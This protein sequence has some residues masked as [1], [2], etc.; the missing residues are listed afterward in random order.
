MKMREGGTTGLRTSRLLFL[1]G[2]VFIAMIITAASLTIWQL[3]GDRIAD[4]MTDTR[5]LGIVL[6]AQTARTIQAVDLIV[7]ETQTMVLAAGL[8][9]PDQ[10]RQRM[11]TEDVHQFLQD[12]L[13][14]LPQA[15]AI[16]I[17]DDAGKIVNFSRTWP[18]PPIDTSDRDFFSYLRDHDDP[19]PFI[20]VPVINKVTGAW[21]IT[22]TR[23]I[24]GPHGEF[25]GIVLGVID[26]R[27]FENFWATSIRATD[28]VALF[29]SD[30]ILLARYP[31]VEKMIGQPIS[32]KSPW[33]EAA[34]SGGKTYRS[35]SYLDGIA[36]IVSVEQVHDFPLAVSATSSEAEALAPWRRRSLLI[37]IGALGAI[38]GFS[39]LLRA[40][41]VQFRRFSQS[42][43]RFRG[44]ALTS[45]DWF[46]ETDEHHRFSYLSPGI[47][48]FGDDR[49]AY[50]GHTRIEFAADAR[51]DTAKWEEHLAV[52]NRHEPF[53]GFS[54]SRNLADGSEAI[55][56]VSGDP[57]FDRSGRFLGYRG[58]ARDI[59][60]QVMDERILREAKEVAETASRTKSQF[61]A[62]VS[63]ELRTPL[64]AII[65]FSEMLE[66]GFAG[67]VQPKQQEYAGL[68]HQSGQ[69]LL[70]IINDILDLAHVESGKFEL[71]EEA[72]VDPRHIIDACVLL[73]RDRAS[74]SDLH[75]STEIEGR[76]PLLVAD[77]TRL[78][79]VLLNLISNAIKFTDPGG[80]IVVAGHQVRDGAIVFE[81][82]D[83]GLGMTPEEIEIALEPFGQ[84]DASNT[85]RHEGPG[86]GLPLARRLAEL[87]GGSLHVSSE[88]GLGTTVAVILPASRIV[89]ATILIGAEYEVDA[90]G[91]ESSRPSRQNQ[92]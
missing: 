24:S 56:S 61:L 81:V 18:V 87:H 45:S 5:H 35:P 34:A 19:R 2:T 55:A 31:R 84:V 48:D 86:L 89:D 23:R 72:G 92:R 42:E 63:H 13:R 32:R 73:M 50:I 67:S 78:K 49:A 26:T 30:G 69:H 20:G 76:L 91:T 47:G 59:T 1:S 8:A 64:N 9:D 54:Y 10:F 40:L 90:T 41:A 28:S 14:S 27:Y 62:N 66:Q 16:S 17:I 39:I 7:Q 77:P 4:E 52:L 33:Y 22:L 25:I 11:A 57:F 85:R 43:A 68:V 82:R 53:R 36:R 6:A 70:D 29:R 21:V 51:T 60:K 74:A 15:D 79:Q 58:T 88:K 38:I 75:L 3:H 44:Y 83:S 12:R 37:A 46:W 80:S 71:R 65:G